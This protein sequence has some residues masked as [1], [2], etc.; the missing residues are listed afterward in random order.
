[1]CGKGV[2]IERQATALS[3]PPPQK[4]KKKKDARKRGGREKD[5]EE[6][7]NDIKIEKEKAEDRKRDGQRH[8]IN[9]I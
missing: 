4:K 5:R 7:E 6:S 8:A 1:M 9:F 3:P 2:W